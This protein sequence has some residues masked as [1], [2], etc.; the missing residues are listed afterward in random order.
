MPVFTT[1]KVVTIG[2]KVVISVLL[3]FFE[4]GGEGEFAIYLL[5]ATL[6]ARNLE[7]DPRS[8]WRCG[9]KRSDWIDI[10]ISP[11]IGVTI[12][13]SEEG[14][15]RRSQSNLEPRQTCCDH[16]LTLIGDRKVSPGHEI[17]FN[18]MPLLR[19]NTRVMT[20]SQWRNRPNETRKPGI[21]ISLLDHNLKLTIRD[22]QIAQRIHSAGPKLLVIQV[23]AQ[24]FK[25]PRRRRVFVQDTKTRL[26]TAPGEVRQKIA[27]LLSQRGQTRSDAQVVD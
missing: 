9:P 15:D 23:R 21:Q 11:R 4:S 18:R 10:S 5:D 7:E 6:L 12:E 1:G 8:I 25:R 22:K 14:I 27:S 20:S 3:G 13:H 16:R 24:Q 19:L 2:L 17:D 26:P